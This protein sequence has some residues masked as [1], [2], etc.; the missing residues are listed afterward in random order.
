VVSA[1]Q[2]DRLVAARAAG[3]DLAAFEELVRRYQEP[4]YRYLWRMCRNQ[5]EAEDMAQEALVKAW[6]GLGGFRGR[7]SFKTWLF[8]IGTN[9]CLNRLSRAR[10]TEPLDEE[11]PGPRQ[12]EPEENFRQRRAR[13]CVRLA[14]DSLPAD[15]R[16]VLVLWAY[17]GMSYDE[18]AEATGRTWASVNALLYRAR[19]TL[20]ERLA[21]AR[22]KGIV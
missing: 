6:V 12:D 21:E 5:A 11:L 13:A 3:G 1:E 17:E 16:T 20:R 18:I 22:D 9:L 7:A 15:Q 8:R 4:L 2:D 19:I 14:V 10:R